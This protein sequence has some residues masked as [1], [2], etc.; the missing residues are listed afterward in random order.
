MSIGK[1]YTSENIGITSIQNSLDDFSDY[2]KSF[3]EL[4]RAKLFPNKPLLE[5]VQTIHDL[6]DGKFEYNECKC[7][8]CGSYDVNK[9]SFCDRTL[10]KE[11]LVNKKIN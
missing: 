3:N 8:Y 6:D 4:L 10:V 9:K 11:F 1:T 2:S 7:V 5:I